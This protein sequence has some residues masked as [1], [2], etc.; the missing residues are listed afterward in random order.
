MKR[1]SVPR[2]ALVVLAIVVSALIVR[3]FVVGVS[4]FRMWRATTNDPSARDFFFTSLE[5]DIAITVLYLLFGW[6]ILYVLRRR[7]RKTRDVL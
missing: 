3:Q 5:V 4:D 6:V 7:Q 2:A 1:W